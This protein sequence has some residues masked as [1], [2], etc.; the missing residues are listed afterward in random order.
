PAGLA[1]E[2]LRVWRRRLDPK[3]RTAVVHV[4]P[5]YDAEGFD[6]RRLA[7]GV[8]TAG[9][10]DAEDLPALV[11][12]ARFAEGRSGPAE[13]YAYLDRQVA[14]FISGEGAVS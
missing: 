2:V 3:R 8:A 9:I 1:G 12:I 14:R 11:E 4:N 10:R 5:V 7:A 13:L 6:V